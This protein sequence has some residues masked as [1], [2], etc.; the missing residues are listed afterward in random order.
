MKIKLYS[1]NLQNNYPSEFRP[2]IAAR[3]QEANKYHHCNFPR[4]QQCNSLFWLY[5]D[6]ETTKERKYCKQIQIHRKKNILLLYLKELVVMV[7]GS[8]PRGFLQMY[9]RFPHVFVIS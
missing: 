8:T 3:D 7:V 9:S 2:T 5:I 1:Q 6:M 4:V